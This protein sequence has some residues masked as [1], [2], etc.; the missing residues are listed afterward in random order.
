M[1]AS[2]DLLILF[3]GIKRAYLCKHKLC[4]AIW[5]LGQ[6]TVSG[7]FQLAPQLGVQERNMN[8]N[9]VMWEKNSLFVGKK[10][11]IF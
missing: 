10:I 4:H 1:I 3:W 7:L 8:T 6:K 2:L 5:P 11:I 9:L